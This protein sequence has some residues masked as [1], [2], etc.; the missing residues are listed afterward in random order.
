MYSRQ[1]SPPSTTNSGTYSYSKTASAKW[2]LDQCQLTGALRLTR[3]TC[4]DD[5]KYRC[6][7]AHVDQHGP[8][9]QY[10]GKWAFRRMVGCQEPLSTVFSL[11]NLAQHWRGMQYLRRRTRAASARADMGS[12]VS[13]QWR[14]ARWW[15]VFYALAS[16][17]LWVWSAVFHTRDVWITERGDYLGAAFA[18]LCSLQ[19]TSARLFG[20][21]IPTWLS[22]MGILAVFARHAYWL[23]AFPRFDYGYNM[24]FNVGIGAVHNVI[25]IVWAITEIVRARSSGY[26]SSGRIRR[27]KLSLVMTVGLTLSMALELFDFAPWG[28]HLDAHALWHLS[29]IPLI[30]VWYQFITEDALAWAERGDDDGGAGSLDTLGSG[31][32]SSVGGSK[33]G[34]ASV[35]SVSSLGKYD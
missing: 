4:E 29:T 13:A 26:D 14:K 22:A 7:H 24:A 15:A 8:V 17:H 3:W 12:G 20:K 27:A 34:L 9:H 5:C 33:G 31:Q 11:G 28:R 30:P 6:M 18:T 16:I 23:L 25:W 35:S 21:W 32:W 2:P 1:S 10:H 19:W